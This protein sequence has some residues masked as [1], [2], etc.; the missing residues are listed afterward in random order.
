MSL[1]NY[2]NRSRAR[3][4]QFLV[5]L[6]EFCLLGRLPDGA[7]GTAVG[8]CEHQQSAGMPLK[9]A[10]LPHLVV[11]G[12]PKSHQFAVPVVGMR[13][14][15]SAWVATGQEFLLAHSSP[16]V[17]RSQIRNHIQYSHEVAG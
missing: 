17:V 7:I 8:S 1:Q 11:C 4:A 12:L 13:R 3:Q 10:K 15:N 6:K 5:I 16:P 2:N 9:G 14:S